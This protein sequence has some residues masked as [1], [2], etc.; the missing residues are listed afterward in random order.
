MPQPLRAQRPSLT[1]VRMVRSPRFLVRANQARRFN[2]D[3]DGGMIGRRGPGSSDSGDTRQE[4]EAEP[5]VDLQQPWVSRHHASWTWTASN[6]ICVEDRSRLGTWVDGKRIDEPT[7]VR[8][9]QT[10]AFGRENDAWVLRDTLPNLHTDAGRSLEFAVHGDIV[11]LQVTVQGITGSRI[12]EVWVELVYV[13]A[14]ADWQDREDGALP[15]NAG[16][17]NRRWIW[18]ALGKDDEDF[19]TNLMSTHWHRA[20]K[21]L[22]Q[23]ISETCL[24]TR[25]R[26]TVSGTRIYEYRFNPPTGGCRLPRSRVVH[27][28]A[29]APPLLSGSSSEG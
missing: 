7:V 9:G 29:S 24:E 3:F 28:G 19:N 5:D 27:R 11:S 16:W 17:R 23:L 21:R 4:R 8:V 15:E 18:S 25:E 10:I 12:A 2:A 26:R 13:L 14:E 1:M 6:E 22:E 20:R